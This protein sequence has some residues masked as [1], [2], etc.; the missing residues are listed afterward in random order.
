MKSAIHAVL[1]GTLGYVLSPE[2]IW[3]RTVGESLLEAS[4]EQPGCSVGLAFVDYLQLSEGFSQLAGKRTELARADSHHA[5][6]RDC[7][8]AAR[9]KAVEDLFVEPRIVEPVAEDH[10]RRWSVRNPIVEVH[11]IEPTPFFEVV[12]G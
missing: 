8:K 10:I 4:S 7:E 12:F 6:H 2:I 9:R 11:H 3:S 1:L 5:L